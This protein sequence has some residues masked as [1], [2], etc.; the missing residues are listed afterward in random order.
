MTGTKVDMPT[1]EVSLNGQDI[2]SV[3]LAIQCKKFQADNNVRTELFS[4]V[5]V[6]VV[7]RFGL[8]TRFSEHLYR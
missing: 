4:L 3:I 2:P 5:S 8:V 6:S 7:T 1:L